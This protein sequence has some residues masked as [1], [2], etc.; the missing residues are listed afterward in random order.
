M[1]CKRLGVGLL[2]LLAAGPAAAGS[3][4]IGLYGDM[5]ASECDAGLSAFITTN[6]YVI[7]ILDLIDG[8]YG[9]D[10]L[11]DNLPARGGPG[12]CTPHWNSSLVIGDPWDGVA[13]VFM[14][15]Q[16]GPLV[17]LGRLEFLPLSDQWVGVDHEL[18]V[19]AN[20]EA[21][22]DAPIILDDNY[23]EQ[24][25]FG[26]RFTFNCGSGGNCGC[27]PEGTVQ[28]NWSEVKQLY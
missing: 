8:L 9:V 2:L 27:G 1:M 15:Q 12:Y 14:D 20:P 13:V 26:G 5:A 19:R 3:D 6:V 25:V 21:Q 16:Y 7:A 10:F 24:G 22:L 18:V 4:M 17:N 11:V 23:E 28:S